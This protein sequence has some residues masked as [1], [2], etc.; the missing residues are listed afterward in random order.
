MKEKNQRGRQKKKGRV[1]ERILSESVH[2]CPQPDKTLESLESYY[3]RQQCCRQ[4]RRKPSTAQEEDKN[5]P[6]VSHCHCFDRKKKEKK[7][8]EE[9]KK[10]EKKRKKKERKKEESG[11]KG[12]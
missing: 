5:L 6:G 12:R 3:K 10:E 1:K 8:K 9:R 11:K 7:K 4:G 2:N